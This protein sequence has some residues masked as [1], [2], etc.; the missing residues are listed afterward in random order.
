LSQSNHVHTLS[1]IAAET[2][3]TSQIT[4]SPSTKYKL[5]AGGSEYIFISTS[6]KNVE[7]NDSNTN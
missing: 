1:I 7:Q 6:D 4:L 2:T 3:D 5:T